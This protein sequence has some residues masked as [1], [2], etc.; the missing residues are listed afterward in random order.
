MC[1]LEF[2]PERENN[3]LEGENNPLEGENNPGLEEASCSLILLYTLGK[4]SGYTHL[5]FSLPVQSLFY[6]LRV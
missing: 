5:V 4:R 2:L 1:V 6:C 3:L